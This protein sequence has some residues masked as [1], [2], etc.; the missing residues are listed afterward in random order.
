MYLRLNC[1]LMLN[2][3]V[4]NGTVFDI[5]TEL[6]NTDLFWHLTLSKQNLYLYSTKLA[7]LEAWINRIA[8]NRNVCQL[9][10][11]LTL[12]WI[13]WN[14]TEYL[15]KM[16]LALNNQQRFICH[17]P[18][19][20]TIFESFAGLDLG[21]NPGLLDNWRTLIIYPPEYKSSPPQKAKKHR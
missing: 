15:Y 2:W 4:W 21:L 19:Q 16:D 5:G 9:N 6:F 20:P 7:E 3:I 8:W 17:K 14:K 10:C 13:V 11:V 12:N 1:V 18:S